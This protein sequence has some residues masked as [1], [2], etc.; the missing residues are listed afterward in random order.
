MGRGKDFR[1][2]RRRGF[3]DDNFSPSDLHGRGPR[4]SSYG[5]PARESPAAEG[6]PVEAVVKWFNPDKGFGFVV[7]GNGAG[8]AFLHISVL[9]AAGRQS[10][11]PGAKMHAHVGP[12]P[13]GSQVTRVLDID[14][15]AAT[16]QPRR[17][18]SG[19]RAGGRAAVDPSIAVEIGGTVKWFNGDKGF[20]FIGAE[21][22]GKDIFVHIS[23]LD[24]AG[25]NDLAE[26][27]QVMV[28]V[29]ETPKGREALSLALVK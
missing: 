14:E 25:L 21:D 12:G 4:Q 11:L 16:E 3:D 13:K 22:G 5:N 15:S 7:L 6:P 20:G 17:E 9:Q 19:P 23:I 8:D 24:R 18:R 27:Q 26:G 28:R 10:I 2:P 1:E 29:V